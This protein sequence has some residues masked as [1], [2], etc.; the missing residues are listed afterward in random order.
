MVSS[1]YSSPVLLNWVEPY[2]VSGV[3]KTLF[4]TEVNTNF[5]VGDRVF[6]INGNYDS[7]LVIQ[8]DKYNR[9]SDGYR[10]L[11]VDNCRLVLDIDYTGVLPNKGNV[12]YG[13]K[14]SD[15]IGLYYIDSYESYLNACR[16]ITTR[17]GFV[18]DKFNYYQNNIAFID[19]NHGPVTGNWGLLSTGISGAPGFFLKNGKTNWTDISNDF[20]VR[21][22]YSL[23][24]S[25]LYYNN[26]KI[27]VMGKSF[28][29][30]GFEFKEGFVYEWDGT[31]WVVD[32]TEESKYAKAIISKSNFRDGTF[33]G[34]FNNGLYGTKSKKIS[35]TGDGSWNGGTLLNSVWRSGTMNSTINLPVSYKSSIDQYG[36]PQQ[37]L[38]GINNNGYGFNYII[39]CEM[40]L[41]DLDSGTIRNTKIGSTGSALPVVKNHILGAATNF[42][43]VITSGLFEF[44]EFNNIHMVG[45]VMK[46]SR[47]R[48][49]KFT[50]VKSVNSSFDNSVFSESTFIS[51]SVIKIL[52]YDEWSS[53]NR[54]SANNNFS[55]VNDTNFKVYKFYIGEADFFR[56]KQGD[57]FYIKGLRVKDNSG[58]ILN[59]F[60]R[61]YRIGCWTE[62]FDE[63]ATEQRG[64]IPKDTFYKRGIEYTAFLSTQEDN[65]QVY[66]SVKYNTDNTGYATEIVGVNTRNQYSIDVFVSTRDTLDIPV[67]GL[68]FNYSTASFLYSG[69]ATRSDKIGDRIDVNSAYIIDSNFESGVIENSDWNGGFIINQNNDLTITSATNSDTYSLYVSGGSLVAKTPYNAIYPESMT[70]VKAGDVLFLNCVEYDT[71]GK[72]IS[73]E[74]IEPGSGYGPNISSEGAIIPAYSAESPKKDGYGLRVN[75]TIDALGSVN[76]VQIISHGLGYSVG[77]ILILTVSGGGDAKVKITAVDNG[78]VRLPEAYEVSAISSGEIIMSEIFNG[79]YSV[80]AGLTAGGRFITEK[81]DNRWGYLSKTKFRRSKLKQ[82]LFKRAYIQESLIQSEDYDSADKDYNNMDKAKSLVVSDMVFK[83]GNNILSSATYLNSHF[84][85]GTDTID[86]GIIQN[87]ILNGVRF[88]KGVVKESSWTDGI[89]DGGT[90]YNSRTFD[91]KSTQDV[92]YYYSNNI[93]AYYAKGTTTATVSNTRNSWRSGVFNGGEF[94]KGDWEDGLFNGGVFYNSKWY[95]GTMSGG[96]LGDNGTPTTD[97]ILYNGVVN[98]TT[99]ENATV[100]AKDVNH[101]P[102]AA[103]VV[104]NNGVFNKGV[105]GSDGGHSVWNDGIFNGGQFVDLAVWKNGVFNGGVF[106]SGY[107]WTVSGSYSISAPSDAHSWQDGV[108]NGGEFGNSSTGTNSTWY[109]GEF[110]GGVFKGRVWNFGVF[111]YGDFEGS[112]AIAIGGLESS[113]ASNFVDSYRTENFYGLWRDGLVTD[114]K[115]IFVK[116]KKFSTI[117][118][119]SV[120][121]SVT[122]TSARIKNALWK[123]GQFNH[124]DGEFH[125][126]VW[127]SGNFEDGKFN[128]S[129]F[130]P[131]VARNGAFKSFDA[132]DRLCYWNG[133]KLNESDFYYSYWNSGV[134]VSGTAYG[135]IF[136]NGTSQYM[137][138][139]NIY[140]ENGT[141]KNGNWNGSNF[142]Y[143]GGITSDFSKAVMLRV[144]TYSN[145]GKYHI[146]NI[147][148]NIKEKNIQPLSATANLPID[149]ISNPTPTGSTNS[150]PPVVF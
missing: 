87:S 140:W 65:E 8:K 127:L 2:K 25:P 6:I 38:N 10:V 123:Y 126:S 32:I 106:K 13:D 80:I 7:D 93:K 142:E 144:A 3:E 119:R 130:N 52:G 90:F 91:G 115:D 73:L 14:I 146:W 30:K 114:K 78:F 81:A 113:N 74:I 62:Y 117:I 105:F 23:A 134:F 132:N 28:V 19:T 82:G 133:G 44:C 116:D 88:T 129:S 43:N 141:W 46:N 24:V 60:D 150:F 124:T 118:N 147:F 53:S 84:V 148:E 101:Y 56:L 145:D 100:M 58:N 1:R 79:T 47:A 64:S 107:G 55:P 37:K 99:V 50:N 94:F 41:S 77:D 95:G 27:R 31:K 57:F 39:D 121:T 61:K 59:F 22:T 34:T 71:R 4:Y 49:S 17:G 128:Y 33:K 97:T 68:N 92:P 51:D 70:S 111:T 139:N 131:Y 149:A 75:N 12:Q 137:N 103:Q 42:S 15:Y 54:K 66:N 21:G 45:G 143:D 18:D 48:N 122:N 16:Q 86:N 40:A 120:E 89:F 138:A 98:Y 63:Y 104:W 29:Y 26:G 109:T 135:M 5:Q 125:N 76:G 108:F 83:D 11:A 69:V 96:V 136:R 35:W 85:G 112:G 72:V 110:N 9:G 102:K 67:S 20:F 36:M